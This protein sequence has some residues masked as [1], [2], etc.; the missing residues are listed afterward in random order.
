[1]VAP[2]DVF[3]VVDG[4]PKWLGAAESLQKALM[5]AVHE[6]VGLYFVFSQKTGN[7]QFY[8]IDSDGAVQRTEET[9]SSTT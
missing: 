6:G 9:V 5:L 3:A 7:K 2:L 4:Q 8:K 1:M